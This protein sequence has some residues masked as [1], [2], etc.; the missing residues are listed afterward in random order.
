MRA[1]GLVLLV[2]TCSSNSSARNL[3]ANAI[4]MLAATADG[5]AAVSAD[6]AGQVRLW[7]EL[8]GPITLDLPPPKALAIGRVNGFEIAEVDA[9]G[10]LVI[11]TVDAGGKRRARVSLA[12]DPPFVGVA[13]STVGVVAWRADHT[14]V[15]VASDGHIASRIAAP[16][17]NRIVAVAVAGPRAVVSLDDGY[18]PHL[19]H[20][21]LG[22]KLAWGATLDTNVLAMTDLALSP[23]GRWIG[24]ILLGDSTR[25]WVELVD[26]ATGKVVSEPETIGGA[27]SIAFAD[28][29]HL[30]IVQQDVSWIDVAH[31]HAEPTWRDLPRRMAST[32]AGGGG[33]VI[34]ATRAQLHVATPP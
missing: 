14:I 29:S 5:R 2:V 32:S 25:R 17:H 1:V 7:P 19:R 22:G 6:V 30:A 26:A 8:H 11:A 16:P 23:N 34:L 24:M 27:R 4:V 15:V 20:L 31:P 28:S 10:D 12:N 21:A 33:R 3:P 18:L 13:M 9:A